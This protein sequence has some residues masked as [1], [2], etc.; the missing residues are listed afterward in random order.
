MKK[1]I[2]LFCITAIVAVIAAVV[3]SIKPKEFPSRR[4]T[5][6]DTTLGEANE[7]VQNFKKDQMCKVKKT[8][9]WLDAAWVD[10][11]YSIIAK[12]RGDGIRIY[13]AKGKDQKNTIVIVS[14]YRIGPDTSKLCE[15]HYDHE[16][17]FE[18]SESF[19]DSKDRILSQDS[20]NDPGA[21][22]F[23][24]KSPCP[25]GDCLTDLPNYMSCSKAYKAVHN[26][27]VQGKINTYSEW[28]SLGVLKTIKDDLH[29][30]TKENPD[31][32]GDG[33]RIYFAKHDRLTNPRHKDRHAFIIIPTKKASI[34]GKYY[35]VDYFS[36]PSSSASSKLLFLSNDNG[37]QCLNNCTGATLPT[38]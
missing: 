36:C 27:E 25:S 17:Y 10:N 8:A 1:L 9:L 12:E 2:F 33:I 16:D 28:F 32:P 21:L 15:S 11:V 13:F 7:M 34:G 19:F 38:N 3:L 35:H 5:L 29:N 37:E 26:C 6:T 14:T 23:G 22:L 18:H 24:D 30:Q 20:P 4:I 31:E